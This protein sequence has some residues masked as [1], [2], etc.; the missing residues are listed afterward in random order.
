MTETIDLSRR[1]L[2]R[3][4]ESVTRMPWLVSEATFLDKCTRC[5]LCMDAC[6]TSIIKIG[7]GGYPKVDFALAEC[8][9]CEKCV[10]VCP[11][12]V[13]DISQ[14]VPWLYK[15]KVSQTCLAEQGVYCRTCSDNCETEAI[16]FRP[17]IS[18]TPQIK[19]SDCSGCGGCVAPC[20][21]QAISIQSIQ[22]GANG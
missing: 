9:F 16:S 15:A 1:F 19:L 18:E 5:G 14:P 3:R 21:V 12:P 13:F 17:G 4:Q 20:P 22:E 8:S 11:E 2:L 10:Q 6:E 7:D